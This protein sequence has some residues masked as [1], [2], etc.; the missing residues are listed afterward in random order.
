MQN[1]TSKLV[2]LRGEQINLVMGSMLTENTLKNRERLVVLGDCAI[3]RLKTLNVKP[4][5]LIDE[6]L[7]E[8]EQL[9]LLKKLLTT[10]GQPSITPVDKVKSKMKRLLSKV[11]R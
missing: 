10:P 9:V 3:Q 5:A 7:D 4:L 2:G 8:I 11:I 6:N 1:L